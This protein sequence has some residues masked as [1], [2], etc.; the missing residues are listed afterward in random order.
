MTKYREDFAL[1]VNGHQVLCSDGKIRTTPELHAL[2][3][4]NVFKEEPILIR[5]QPVMPSLD[6]NDTLGLYAAL[7]ATAP[8]RVTIIQAPQ[9]IVDFLKGDEPD[10]S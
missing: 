10:V 4:Y 7:I 2:I 5:G 1:I 3:L 6:A 9:Q 8:G